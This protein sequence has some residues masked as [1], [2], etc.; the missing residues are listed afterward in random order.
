MGVEG[1]FFGGIVRLIEKGNNVIGDIFFGE[2]VRS[3]EKRNNVIGDIFFVMELRDELK[4]EVNVID[5]LLI[6]YERIDLIYLFIFVIEIA[7]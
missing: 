2:I 7:G 5:N 3:I 1:M 6:E 4:K